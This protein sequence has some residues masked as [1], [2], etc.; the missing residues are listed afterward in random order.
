MRRAWSSSVTPFSPVVAEERSEVVEDRPFELLVAEEEDLGRI[1][2]GSSHRVGMCELSSSR[3][4][5]FHP[6]F[7]FCFVVVE[8][9]G[10]GDEE[11][12]A[13]GFHPTF[14]FVCLG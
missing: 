13:S 14:D 2:T 8:L 10:A 3:A 11:E 4:A 5:G 12:K 7:A 6:I 9:V 1:I